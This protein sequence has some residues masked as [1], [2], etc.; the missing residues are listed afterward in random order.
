MR[1]NWRNVLCDGT[2]VRKGQNYFTILNILYIIIII[3]SFQ[4]TSNCQF[5][6]LFINLDAKNCHI[7]SIDQAQ[8]KQY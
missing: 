8:Y 3:G 7:P 4:T 2:Q 5:F 1:N 6:F